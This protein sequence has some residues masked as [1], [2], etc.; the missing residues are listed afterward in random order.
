MQSVRIVQAVIL[1]L[2]VAL[3]AGCAA[4][5]EYAAKIFPSQ[6]DAEKVQKATALRF[7]QLD[8]LEQ[9][10][11]GWVTTDI[12][13]GRDTVSQTKA[14][15]NLA[16]TFPATSS[17]PDTSA[18]S[19]LAKKNDPNTDQKIIITPKSE[20]PVAKTYNTGEIREKRTRD[21]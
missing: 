1:M 20:E 9:K 21:D 5:R 18:K 17:I 6:Q 14:L 11:D 8:S 19:A 12:I 13:M 15:D 3:A 7:L 10:E 2:I 16:K 4:T